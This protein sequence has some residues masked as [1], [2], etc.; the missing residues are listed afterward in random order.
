[1]SLNAK[2]DSLM[3]KVVQFTPYPKEA[4]HLHQLPQLLLKIFELSLHIILPRR[5]RSRC[6]VFLLVDLGGSYLGS[7]HSKHHGTQD[8]HAIN[9][10]S[11]F[12]IASHWESEQQN[13]VVWTM[14]TKGQSCKELMWTM[15]KNTATSI[16]WTLRHWALHAVKLKRN[17]YKVHKVWVV[18]LQYAPAAIKWYGQQ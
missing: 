5:P 4:H 13:P 2:K 7:L 9:A 12:Y 17:I 14:E 16:W 6:I 15:E 10:C 3:Y 1:M 8:W 18:V 11:G